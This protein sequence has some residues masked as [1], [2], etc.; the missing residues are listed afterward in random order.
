MVKEMKNPL[1]SAIRSYLLDLMPLSPWAPYSETVIFVCR[2]LGCC[3][4]VAVVVVGIQHAGAISPS[5]VLPFGLLVMTVAL[6]IGN[7]IKE[8]AILIGGSAVNWLGREFRRTRVTLSGA[9]M[10]EVY[11][12]DG[13]WDRYIHEASATIHEWSDLSGECYREV[14]VCSIPG[15]VLANPG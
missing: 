7:L 1:G 5:Q 6:P 12:P 2:L 3:T 4:I 9:P 8:V 10:T 14:L 15:A 11:R 13:T